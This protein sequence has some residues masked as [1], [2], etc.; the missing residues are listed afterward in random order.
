MVGVDLGEAVAGRWQGW[1]FGADGLL[2]APVWR[3]GLHEGEILAIPYLY[4]LDA[5]FRRERAELRGEIETLEKQRAA[6]E[7]DAARLRRLVRDEARLGLM[8]Q[9][10]TV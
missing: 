9:R 5:A 6:A 10:I 7:I 8:L 1:R 3:R 4:A 2:Y